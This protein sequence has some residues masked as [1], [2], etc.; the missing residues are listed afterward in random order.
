MNASGGVG[1]ALE[2]VE[3]GAEVLDGSVEEVADAVAEFDV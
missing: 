1:T 2:D 3:I